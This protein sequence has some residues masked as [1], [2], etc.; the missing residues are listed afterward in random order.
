MWPA[1]L[2]WP[3]KQYLPDSIPVQRGSA[4]VGYCQFR[5]KCCRRHCWYLFEHHYW[6]PGHFSDE[7]SI[8]AGMPE[9]VSVLRLKFTLEFKGSL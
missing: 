4:I 1:D 2:G 7:D 8:R 3:I 9:L 5:L 6:G